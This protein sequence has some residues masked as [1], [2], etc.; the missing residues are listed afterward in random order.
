MGRLDAWLAPR[1]PHPNDPAWLA[2]QLSHPWAHDARERRIPSPANWPTAAGSTRDR[3]DSEIAAIRFLKTLV[4]G[5][6][7]GELAETVWLPSPSG[8]LIETDGASLVAQPPSIGPGSIR[9][10]RVHSYDP[11]ALR[12]IL[13]GGVGSTLTDRLLRGTDGRLV[14]ADVIGDRKGRCSVWMLRHPDRGWQV[15]S[16]PLPPVDLSWRASTRATT[17]EDERLRIAHRYVLAAALAQRSELQARRHERLPVIHTPSGPV[18]SDGLAPAKGPRFDLLNRVV[19]QTVVY[20][21]ALPDAAEGISRSVRTAWK[22]SDQP[23]VWTKTPVGRLDNGVIRDE[24][25]WFAL[26]VEL[27]ERQGPPR[28]VARVAGII[29][30]EPL[31]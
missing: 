16:L 12:R 7:V 30:G 8:R 4:S 22:H 14:C 23:P 29:P 26:V 24:S 19:G 28:R 11:A 27:W 18:A 25:T 13:P 9:V 6:D 10:K 2:C 1:L 17:D 20:R 21:E 15:G 5:G 3:V 31:A